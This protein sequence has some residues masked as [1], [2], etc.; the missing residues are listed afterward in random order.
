MEKCKPASKPTQLN[1]ERISTSLSV[2][3]P[4]KSSPR[5]HSSRFNLLHLIGFHCSLPRNNYKSDKIG[6]RSHRT[7]VNAEAMCNLFA[8]KSMP[9]TAR[10]KSK[11]SPGRKRRTRT[12][13]RTTHARCHDSSA[14]TQTGTVN[15]PLSLFLWDMMFA[16]FVCERD[17]K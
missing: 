5:N 13:T 12:R 14:R 11:S 6:A 17:A 3:V 4:P 15:N 16:A 10:S 9:Q 8:R 1:Y 7:V 2:A